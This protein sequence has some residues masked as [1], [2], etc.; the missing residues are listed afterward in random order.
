MLNVSSKPRIINQH[1]VLQKQV[2]AESGLPR[3]GTARPRNGKA[4]Q[5]R[6]FSGSCSFVGYVLD[7]SKFAVWLVWALGH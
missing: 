3:S 5:V 1:E 6:V 7:S 2:F 4:T